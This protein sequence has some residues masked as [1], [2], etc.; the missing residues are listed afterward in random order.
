MVLILLPEVKPFTTFGRTN[1]MA[2]Y[3]RTVLA[4][5]DYISFETGRIEREMVKELTPEKRD[6]LRVEAQT[7]K[8]IL[9][10]IKEEGGI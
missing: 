8:D 1:K 6:M 5:V 10:I 2:N 9:D 4:I 7:L 3:K